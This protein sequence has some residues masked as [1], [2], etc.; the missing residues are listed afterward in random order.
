MNVVV[1]LTKTEVRNAIAQFVEAKYGKALVKKPIDCDVSFTDG[2]CELNAGAEDFDGAM[3][4]V[5]LTNS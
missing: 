2:D 5:Q 1:H 3:V 4:K